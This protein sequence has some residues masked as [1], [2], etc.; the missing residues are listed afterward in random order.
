MC[1]TVIFDSR[2]SSV[3]YLTHVPLKWTYLGDEGT[4][5]ESLPTYL[6]AGDIGL[7]LLGVHYVLCYFS[8]NYYVSY[9]VSGHHFLCLRHDIKFILHLIKLMMVKECTKINSYINVL[10]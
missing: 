5:E 9:V 3:T 8:H 10:N 6:S 1:F 7:I 2:S 4:V